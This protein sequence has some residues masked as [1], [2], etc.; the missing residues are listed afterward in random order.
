MKVK[1]LC[2]II[3]NGKLYRAGDVF[4][5]DKALPNTI[6]YEKTPEPEPRERE[7][8]EDTSENIEEIPDLIGSSSRP[9]R[10]RR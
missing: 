7:P 10:R 6:Q 8:I 1:A 5:V 9:G 2:N 4:E 3:R